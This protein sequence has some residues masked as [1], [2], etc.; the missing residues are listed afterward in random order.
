MDAGTH[1]VGGG[2]AVGCNCIVS[3]PNLLNAAPAAV[4]ISPTW[5]PIKTVPRMST[6]TL[7]I[8]DFDLEQKPNE[9]CGTP[10][11]NKKSRWRGPNG[12][13]TS[14]WVHQVVVV[15]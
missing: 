12:L 3:S 2:S 13:A 1:P 6:R 14:F 10:A 8:L 4:K 5:K 7:I 11:Q 9:V 15:G